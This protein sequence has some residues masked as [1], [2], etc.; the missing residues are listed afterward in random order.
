MKDVVGRD[1]MI[2][3]Q[4]NV[5]NGN[6]PSLMWSNIS[7]YGYQWVEPP[8]VVG[9][10]AYYNFQAPWVKGVLQWW[11]KCYNEGLLDPEVFVKQDTQLNEEIVRGRFAIFPD[12]NLGPEARKFAKENG[13]TF[14]YRQLDNSWPKTAKATYSDA[15]HKAVSYYQHFNAN[16]ITK[17]VK[18]A[19]L[20]QVAAWLDYHYSEEWD[21]MTSWGPPEFWTGE[22]KNRRFR[23]EYKDLENFQA[24]GVAG[25]KDGVYYG[26]YAYSAAAIEGGVNNWEINIAHLMNQWQ[27]APK[28]VYP[29]K[30]ER[31][32]D[33]NGVIKSSVAAYLGSQLITPYPQIGW[34]F[35][36]LNATEGFADI[37]YM[38]F[39]THGPAIAKAITD[40]PANFETNY[41]AYMKVFD[42][43][44]WDEGMANYQEKWEVI[45]D[46]YVKQ[47]W[48]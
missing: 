37:Q 20:A 3:A 10:K 42:D 4:L 38:W 45:Y 18:E 25:G 5:A 12:W 39:G 27:L 28:W 8:F 24:Y 14:G 33:Y 40:S 11:N 36:E 32:M 44:N 22:G 47:Y 43:N 46:K 31:G 9:N 21:V 1:K 2:V 15:S 35:A 6:P 26:I 29:F 48:E 16:L 34:S 30:K 17:T 23:P 19:D 7:M 13:A 41:S